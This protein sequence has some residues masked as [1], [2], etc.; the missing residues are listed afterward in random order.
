MEYGDA[1]MPTRFER[2]RP[3][4]LALVLLPASLHGQKPPALPDLLKSASDYVTQFAHQ[5]GTVAADEEFMQ[6]E[7]ST[8][9]MGTPKRIN[10]VV[11]FMG[12]DDGS[13]GA[14]RDVVAIDSVPVR[15]KDD[16]LAALFRSP[17]A[18]SVTTAQQMSDD[19][20]RAY[21]N[22][23]LHLLDRPLLALDLLRA[24]NQAT[25]TYKIEGMKSVDGVQTAVVKFNEKG[26]GYLTANL[27]AVGRYWIEPATG[28]VRQTE[29]GF[30][31][32]GNLH[33]T[34]KFTKAAQLDVLVPS[35]LSETVEL[36]AGG[37]GMGE[38]GGATGG[39]QMGARQAFEGR[40]TYANYR[41]VK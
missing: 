22:P 8:G 9:R 12:Q 11:V 2:W 27:S 19:A 39:G 4:L 17:S 14:F 7:T 25:W 34:V 3:I 31:G 15:P 10:S 32:G 6:Y 24:E 36:S 21:M 28:A 35:E 30:S 5:L 13:I 1:T 37:N 40:A 16:R 41:R 29:L 33:G 23:N 38:M 20:V 18:A 26:K